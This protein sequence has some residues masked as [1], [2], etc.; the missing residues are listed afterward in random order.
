MSDKSKFKI[1]LERQQTKGRKGLHRYG[2][3]IEKHT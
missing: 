3:M 1:K 2:K